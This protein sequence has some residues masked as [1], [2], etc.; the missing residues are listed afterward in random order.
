VTALLD[1]ESVTSFI[2]GKRFKHLKQA[3]PRLTLQPTQLEDVHASGWSFEVLQ[4]VTASVTI[5]FWR[6]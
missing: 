1:T 4:Y 3:D 6:V 5:L 2:S